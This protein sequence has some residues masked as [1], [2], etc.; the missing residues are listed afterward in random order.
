MRTES[1]HSRS[2]LKKP[3]NK[4]K[5]SKEHIEDTILSKWQHTDSSVVMSQFSKMMDDPRNETGKGVCSQHVLYRNS[6]GLGQLNPH[7]ASL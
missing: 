6:S 2:P 1:A 7:V 3:I 5:A 4:K